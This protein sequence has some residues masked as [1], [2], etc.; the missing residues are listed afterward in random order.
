MQL[1]EVC[2]GPAADGTRLRES[3][4]T[5]SWE[6]ARKILTRGIAEHHPVNRPLFNL[7]GGAA[8][9]TEGDRQTVKEAITQFLDMKRGENII[10]MAHYVGLFEGELLKWC[11]ERGIHYVDE[12]SLELLIKFRNSLKNKGS[13]RNRK[14]SRLRTFFAFC[15]DLRWSPENFARKIK[16]S[17]EDDP[18]V[19]YFHPE[20]MQSL[21]SAC[22]VSHNWERGHDYEYRD[23]RLRALIL[24]ARWTGL[25]II[26]CVR[27]SRDRLQ[28]NTGGVWQV[29]LRRQKNGN[30]VFVAIPSQVVEA[31][32]SIPPMSQMYFFWSANGKAETAVRGWRRSLAHVFKAANLK[33]NGRPLR[34]YPHMFRH[35]FA[36]EKLLG[37]A[38]L[39]DVSLLLGHDS[40]KVTERRT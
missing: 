40:I 35:T 29:L 4:G 20:E 18:D 16:P 13:V 24:F 8:G 1:R 2:F 33:R 32:S 25:A 27:C 6:K 28:Q 15:V 38:S 39:E 11:R 12:L 3:T 10:D 37:G 23:K 9:K 31:V 22:F 30:P 5:A 14:L 21:E 36:I 17:Q 19:D 7:V 34:C 26:D